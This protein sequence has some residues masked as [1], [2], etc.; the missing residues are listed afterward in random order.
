MTINIAI[1]GKGGTGKTTIAGT[2]ARL[3]ARDG[4][5]VLAVDAD[6]DLNLDSVL[7]VDASDVAPIAKKDELITKRTG[8][9]P[10][11]TSI[12]GVFK[13]NPKVNDITETYGVTAP[14]G[15]NLV[16]MGTVDEGGSGCMCPAGAFLRA[17]MRHLVKRRDDAVIL[18]ME[19]G[20]E[21]LGRGTADS[22]DS[23]LVVVEPGLKSVE[24]ALRIK[25]LA[26]DIGLNRIEAVA[27]K[28][29]T[30]EEADLIQER[31]EELGIPLL[32][33]IPFDETFVEADLLGR[34]PLD[35]G[36]DSE[37]IKAIRRIEKKITERS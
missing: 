11:G 31:L 20:I 32:E 18:D 34:A 12:P 9:S 30:K 4:Y 16:V 3:L 35:L 10:G 8:A 33:T 23:M 19:A 5:N 1:A 22:V 26:E 15:V 25:N 27:N 24:T 37:G 21:H 2:L 29:R 17:L 13:L 36:E 6:P 28:I 7:G 14:D